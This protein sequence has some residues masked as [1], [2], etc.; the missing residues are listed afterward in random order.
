MKAVKS[1]GRRLE[2]EHEGGAQMP[3][4]E[5]E[6]LIRFPED[7]SVPTGKTV[8]DFSLDELEARGRILSRNIRLRV[9]GPEEI[10]IIGKNGAGKTTLLRQIAEALQ[11]RN[12]IR[13][14]YMPQNYA[15][16]LD[17]GATPAEF[18]SQN[19]GSAGDGKNPHFPRQH[20]IY[21]R[22][23]GASGT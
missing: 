13:T 19:R 10:C 9:T 14:G 4:A 15:E 12:D 5:D 16:L 3:D 6:I 8:L 23:N 17:T 11:G 1:M 2:R 7:I 18:L 22:R 20:E 21:R